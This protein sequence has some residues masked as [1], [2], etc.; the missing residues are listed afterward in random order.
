MRLGLNLGYAG[1]G[2][3]ADLV[4]LAQVA[5]DLGYAA[6]WVAEAYG[7]DSPTVLAWIGAQTS[8][9]GLGAAVMQIPAR[10]PAMTAMT[11][12][13]LDALSGGRVH[14]GLGVSGPQVSEGWHGVRFADPLGRTR[15]YV[16]IVRM[17]L[18]RHMVRYDG[19]HFTLPLPDGPGKSLSLTLH[20]VRPEIPIYLAAVGPRNLELAGEIADGWL[21]IFFSPEHSGPMLDSIAAGRRTSGK[22]TDENPLEGFE[23]VPTVPVVVTDDI[24]AGMTAVSGYAALYIG[25]MGSRKQNFYNRLAAR[26]G[27]E[28]EAAQVQDLFLDKRHRE[29][30]AAVP[31]EFI[32]ATSLIGP[33]E[34]IAER[35]PRYA[36]AGV[37]MLA[38]AP[39]ALTS[40]D[41]VRSLRVVAQALDDAGL[42]D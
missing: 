33:K 12:A 19:S 9:V 42:A 24:E 2:I 10:T 6:V 41:R 35:L 5:D 17:A 38:V 11:A 34:R 31:R 18:R 27:F 32:D 13:T 29:A 15:E 23:V 25:G 3:D 39:F 14:L 28:S 37:T 7:S 22:G 40:E 16:D 1:M 8:R 21:A 4:S 20:P 26:M 30:A 36:A